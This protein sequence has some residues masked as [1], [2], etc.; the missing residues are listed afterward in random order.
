MEWRP[1]LST[2]SM[3]QSRD[4]SVD[5]PERSVRYEDYNSWPRFGK[6]CLPGTWGGGAG[7]A[8]T[9]QAAAPPRGPEFFCQPAP[10]PNWD[11]SRWGAHYWAQ[12]LMEYGHTVKL[13][14]PQFVRP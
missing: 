3:C 2:A 14:A 5:F 6:E 13:M 12:R 11:G 9:A 4:R 1:L 10:L 7:E 8:A